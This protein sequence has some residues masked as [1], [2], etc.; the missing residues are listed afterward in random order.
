M[1]REQPNAQVN[2]F[3]FLGISITGNLSW[4]SHN[5]TLVKKVHKWLHFLGILKKAKFLYHVLVVFYRG[6]TESI[7]IGIITN[8]HGVLTTQDRRALVRIYSAS[9]I[10][11]RCLPRSQRILK[12]NTHPSH[13]L[14]SWQAIQKYPLPWDQGKPN[15]QKRPSIYTLLYIRFIFQKH[16]ASSILHSF[17]TLGDILCCLSSMMFFWSTLKVKQNGFC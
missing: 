16:C 6:A 12:D 1:H 4:T 8:W 9:M 15:V 17:W 10:S 5:S 13:S 11:V 3:R 7:I 2:S 14:F